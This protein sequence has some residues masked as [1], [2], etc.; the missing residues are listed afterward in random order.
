MS[1]TGVVNFGS[2]FTAGGMV[3]NYSAKL[4]GTRLRLTDG[5]IGEAGSAWYPTPANVQTFTTDF[6]VQITPG[7]NPAA[8]GFTFVIQ[9]NDTSAIDTWGRGLGYG[10][11]APGGTPASPR[12][13]R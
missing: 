6:S 1:S 5:G 3:L 4:N 7:K 10:P 12:A 9:G 13:W 11:N 2:G 8:D